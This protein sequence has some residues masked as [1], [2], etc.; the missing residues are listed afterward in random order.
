MSSRLK[1]FSTMWVISICVIALGMTAA[2]QADRNLEPGIALAGS[3]TSEELI[4]VYTFAGVTEQEVTLV[5]ASEDVADLDVV[6]VD[7]QG[8]PVSLA[9][10]ADANEG[11]A[12]LSGVLPTD[13]TYYV[14]VF[15]S[16]LPT[17]GIDFEITLETDAAVVA[18][19]VATFT[20]PGQL[21]TATGMQVRLG[22]NTNAN[23]DLEVRD[24]VGG[25]LFW[26][27]P[28]VN[29]GGVF[30]VNANTD[31]ANLNTTSPFEEA[32]WPTGVIPTGSYEL[33]VYYQQ[34]DACPTTGTANVTLNVTVDGTAATAIQGAIQP[35]QI[36]LASF[37]VAN[38]GTITVRPGGIKVD[39]PTATGID[40]SEPL[41]VTV[42]TEVTGVLTNGQVYQAYSFAATTGQSVSLDM[43][44]TSGNLDTLLLL[45][46]PNGNVVSINDDRETGNTNSLIPNVPLLLQGTYT[47]I[48]TRYGQSIGGTQGNYVLSLTNPQAV[49]PVGD[50]A[51][52]AVASNLPLLPA[53]S[54]QV[55][56]QWSTNADI[57]LLV[58]EPSGDSIYDDRTTSNSGGIL[59]ANGNVNCV[60]A[61]SGTP[62]SYIYWPE[63]R[64]PSP[65]AYEIQVWY[66]NNCNDTRPV[67]FN[68]T[69]TA[70]GNVIAQRSET[71][72]V[73]EQYV[74]SYEIGLDGQITGGEGGF[75]GTVQRPD[76][77]AVNFQGQVDDAQALI[78]NQSVTGSIRLDRRFDVYTFEGLANQEI[79]IVMEQLNGTLDPVLFMVDPSGIQVAQNDDATPETRNSDVSYTLPADGEYII[80]ATHYGGRFGVTQ[81]DYRLTLRLN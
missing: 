68:L 33:I 44:A 73:G 55:S 20:P 19:P 21:L 81:G 57:Q 6:L 39:P 30:G 71:I 8:E 49:L 60:P 52:T 54:V 43:S 17:A 14:T 42:G 22:W 46:D 50:G 45:L 66:Q 70:G 4:Q 3:L 27:R 80:I 72:R 76:V 5:V 51:A 31:C 28:Q 58:R 18:D 48:A 9:A 7:E 23:L 62:I 65:G 34:Q 79:Q 11:Q 35:G 75:F 25:S 10:P 13:G 26:E 2:A 41:A 1:R 16:D 77:T 56:L 36:F 29:S 63:G 47:I 61:A 78:A 40:V 67:T 24:P 64:L 32:S 74:I 69:V 37:D 38:D 12:T 59:A 53:G 15:S